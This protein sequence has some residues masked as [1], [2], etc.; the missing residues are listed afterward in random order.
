[1]LT[2]NISVNRTS[3]K[4]GSEFTNE[5]AAWLKKYTNGI[6]TMTQNFAL[7]NFLAG[8]RQIRFL[9]APYEHS[10]ERNKQQNTFAG[11]TWTI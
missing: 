8:L 2:A 1:L 7:L 3:A 5:D 11:N 10:N 4:I 9:L 6:I